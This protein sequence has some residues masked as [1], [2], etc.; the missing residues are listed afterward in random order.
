V[1][2]A[3]FGKPDAKEDNASVAAAKPE[4]PA[5]PPALPSFLAITEAGKYLSAKILITVIM[6]LYRSEGEIRRAD[7]A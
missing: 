2:G 5:A 3:C 4:E 6:T 7:S 1:D